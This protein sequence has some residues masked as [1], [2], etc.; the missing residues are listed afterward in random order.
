MTEIDNTEY[1]K[2]RVASLEKEV[3]RLARTGD[4]YDF[5]VRKHERDEARR[6]L[7]EATA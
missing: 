5:W 2:A 7:E 1:L 3:A 4:S 6:Q